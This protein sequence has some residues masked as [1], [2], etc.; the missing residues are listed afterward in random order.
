MGFLLDLDRAPDEAISQFCVHSNC[1]VVWPELV[2]SHMQPLSP[3][4]NY[5][6]DSDNGNTHVN[7]NTP[8]VGRTRNVVNS[9]IVAALGKWGN[10]GLWQR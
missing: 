3:S 6:R 2:G 9:A 1:V 7:E 4:D 8:P 5:N 10:Y